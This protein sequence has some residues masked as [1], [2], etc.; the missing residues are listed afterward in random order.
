MIPYTNQLRGEKKPAPLPVHYT[1]SLVSE[2]KRKWKNERLAE[3]SLEVKLRLLDDQFLFNSTFFFI[4]LNFPSK[5]YLINIPNCAAIIVCRFSLI[6]CLLF[7]CLSVQLSIGW[8]SYV[9]LLYSHHVDDNNDEIDQDEGQ[10]KGND[11]GEHF[12]V[13]YE[14]KNFDKVC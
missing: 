12:G 10:V 8:L 1:G 6:V 5:N 14:E 3:M 9:M 11:D 2:C 13:F 7:V 4:L